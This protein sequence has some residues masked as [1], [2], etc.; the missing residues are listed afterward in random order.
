MIKWISISLF[1]ISFFLLILLGFGIL[2]N[3]NEKQHEAYN[4]KL[5]QRKKQQKKRE[6]NEGLAATSI[7]IVSPKTLTSSK[8]INLTLVANNLT[9]V[10]DEQ[11]A[12]VEI[13]FTDISCK[14][15]VNIV[16][17]VQLKK[18]PRDNTKVE[19]CD[20]SAN[21]AVCLDNFCALTLSN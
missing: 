5:E 17:A 13:Y 3:D 10:T 19:H 20:N 11:C 9:C 16:G 8:S 21:T 7:A 6:S 18:A 1:V 4:R 2:L 14:V 12:V 15:A